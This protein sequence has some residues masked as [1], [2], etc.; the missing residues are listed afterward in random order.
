MWIL[1]RRC[2]NK[3][4]ERCPQFIY[5]DKSSLYEE[6]LQEDG[7]FCIYHKNIQELVTEMFKVENASSPE[8]VKSIFV[9]S[10]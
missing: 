8:I 4:Y 7:S 5:N 9:E 6:F 3:I 10:N 1:H 2:I